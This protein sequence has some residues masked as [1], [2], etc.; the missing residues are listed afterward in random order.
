MTSIRAHRPEPPQC[1]ER[2]TRD[3]RGGVRAASPG[4][5]SMLARTGSVPPHRTPAGFCGAAI[6]HRGLIAGDTCGVPHQLENLSAHQ[7]AHVPL[8]ADS[9]LADAV[10]R[11]VAERLPAVLAPTV[12][13]GCAEQHQDLPGTITLRA[14]TLTALAVEQAHGLARQR[15][16]AVVLLSTHGGNRGALDAVVAEL[17]RSLRDAVACAPRSDVGPN[18][19]C[20]SGAWLTSVMLALHQIW[21]SLTAP[22]PNSEPSLRPPIPSRETKP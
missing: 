5:T 19:G 6:S 9:I 20:H 22:T 4:L 16:Q 11:E 14:A 1:A 10:G 17:D 12:R 15:F 18:P 2:A 3:L 7:G 21:L 13:V 8:G